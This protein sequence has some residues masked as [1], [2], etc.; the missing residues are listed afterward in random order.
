MIILDTDVCIEI[1]RGSEIVLE[2]RASYKEETAVSFLTVGELYYGARKSSQ[3]ESNTHLVEEFLGTIDVIPSSDSIMERFGIL[4]AELST[5]HQLLPDA[6]II[7]A[8]C[9]FEY[10]GKLASGNT[11]HFERFSGL[12][13]FNWMQ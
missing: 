10:G 1:L 7:I 12:R 11:R 9:A 13:L 4:K 6:D 2:K 5:R 8:A 3:V